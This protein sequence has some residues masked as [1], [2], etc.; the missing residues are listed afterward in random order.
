M[1]ALWAREVAPDWV[2]R[3]IV[4]VVAGGPWQVAIAVARENGPGPWLSITLDRP[5]PA[6]FVDDRTPREGGGF[7]SAISGALIGRRLTSFTVLPGERILELGTGSHRLVVELMGARPAIA[8]LSP[9]DTILHAHRNGARRRERLEPGS[10]YAPP[11]A[12]TGVR[13][14]GVER[15]LADSLLSDATRWD[16]ALELARTRI[17][18]DGVHVVRIVDRLVV[19]PGPLPPH[20]SVMRVATVDEA[21]RHAYVL[22]RRE[23][24]LAAEARAFSERLRALHKRIARALDACRAD[25]ERADAWPTWERFGSALMARPDL[26]PRGARRVTVPDVFDPDG[27]PLEIPV[28]PKISAIENGAAYIKRAERGK[29]AVDLV[30]ARAERLGHDLEWIDLR[31]DRPREAWSDDELSGLGER[32]E[33]YRV[34]SRPGRARGTRDRPARPGERGFHPRRYRSS[35]GWTILVGRTNAENDW[36][37]H[38]FAKPDDIWLHAQGVAGSHVILRREGKKDNPSRRTLEE[39]AALAAAF[40]KARHSGS[41][42]VVYTLKKYVWKPRKSAPGLAAHRQEKTIMVEP[43]DL[44]TL[45]TA[46]EDPASEDPDRAGGSDGRPS[47]PPDRG[48]T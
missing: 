2:G 22:A 37:T 27:D 19:T 28:D 4:S 18:S 14:P 9:R 39:A 17:T 11:D 47:A 41:V 12:P 20:E 38:R 32:L 33:R 21:A 5:D 1:L 3:P 10:T 46:D 29:R 6:I 15:R 36:L 13:W 48:T 25:Q 34:V 35:D 8:W 24:R 44:N 23:A 43:A 40:S 16:D 26:V 42:P 30:R 7:P 45:R 31:L